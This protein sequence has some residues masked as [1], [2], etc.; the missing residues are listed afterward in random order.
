MTSAILL[1]VVVWTGVLTVA[2]LA[3]MR[4]VTA[5][6][7]AIQQRSGEHFSVDSDGPELGAQVPESLR[8]FLDSCAVTDPYVGVVV[9]SPTCGPCREIVG[10]FNRDRIQSRMRFVALVAGTGAPA[11]ELH[12]LAAEHFDFVE[13]GSIAQAIATDL[14]VH[15]SPFALL[16][17]EGTVAEKAYVRDVSDLHDLG[18]HA[19][20]MQLS[21]MGKGSL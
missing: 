7:L 21:K 4:Q 2:T 20:E 17:G 19:E 14:D 18:A 12:V 10:S 11:D 8:L 16:L 6:Q 15:S 3:I 1:L 13:S 5:M 9:L